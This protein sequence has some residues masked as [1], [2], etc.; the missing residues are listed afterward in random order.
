MHFKIYF[1]ITTNFLILNSLGS[2][3]TLFVTILT[4]AGKAQV[5]PVFCSCMHTD[6]T[7]QRLYFAKCETV[8]YF[9]AK[10]TWKSQK[11][12]KTK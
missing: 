1:G 4:T 10:K 11:Q 9:L 2:Y 5:L 7:L 8:S 12:S 3:K 6:V